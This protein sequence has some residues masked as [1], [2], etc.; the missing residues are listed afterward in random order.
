MPAHINRRYRQSPGYT[1][2]HK[3]SPTVPGALG[4]G[5]WAK[6]RDNG[7]K[8]IRW[9]D[10]WVTSVRCERRF[11]HTVRRPSAGP[12]ICPLKRRSPYERHLNAG[13]LTGETKSLKEPLKHVR[14][15]L[16]MM[17]WVYGSVSPPQKR[18]TQESLARLL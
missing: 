6:E 18:R 8:A 11:L 14:G 13:A 4:A 16:R 9:P 17:C 5:L 2:P 12:N 10:I 3:K 1:E 15:A 7:D